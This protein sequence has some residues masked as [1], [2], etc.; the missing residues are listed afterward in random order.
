MSSVVLYMPNPAQDIH[1]RVT[2]TS[3]YFRKHSIMPAPAPTL[4]AIQAD[5]TSLDVVV[6]AAN[7]S[8]LGGGG[9]D[10]AI[11]HAAGAELLGACRALGGC[12]TGDAKITPGFQLSAPY[13]IHTVG[14]I[15][16]GGTYGE[17]ELL[18]ACYRRS[19]ERAVELEISSIAFPSISTGAYA[20]PLKLAAPIALAAVRRFDVSRSKLR[21]II[22]CCYSQRDYESYRKL[23]S[24]GS[25]RVGS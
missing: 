10:G 13:I 6:N 7:N 19:M 25:A 16:R 3:G 20:F 4:R 8:L 15:W 5:I 23:L 1:V 9:V 14:P 22:F 17:Q 21:E 24:S 12:S 2:I 11:H 18:A